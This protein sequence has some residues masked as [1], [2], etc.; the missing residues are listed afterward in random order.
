M[1]AIAVFELPLE[2]QPWSASMIW[3]KLS[4]QEH[5]CRWLR[6]AV[7]DICQNL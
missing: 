4:D 5:A 7:K 6:N 3:S 1:G 2:L